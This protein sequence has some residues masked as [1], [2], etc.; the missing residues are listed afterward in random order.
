FLYPINH[1]VPSFVRSSTQSLN[2]QKQLNTHV[3]IIL[4]PIS[5]NVRC[6]V[7]MN[8]SSGKMQQPSKQRATHE[9]FRLG[10]W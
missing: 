2:Q 3:N 9:V 1:L 4:P 7:S 5:V 8:L 10:L 6:N